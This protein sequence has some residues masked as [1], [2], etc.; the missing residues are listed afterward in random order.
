MMCTPS[1][2]AMLLHLPALRRAASLMSCRRWVK[3]QLWGL[4]SPQPGSFC[5]QT[6]GSL[7]FNQPHADLPCNDAV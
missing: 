2:R 7:Q 5:I 6:C 4:W 1:V 3:Q